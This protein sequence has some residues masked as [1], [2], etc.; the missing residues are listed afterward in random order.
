MATSPIPMASS[1]TLTSTPYGTLV[2]GNFTGIAGSPRSRLAMLD[3]AG[4]N[5]AFFAGPNLSSGDVNVSLLGRRHGS[6]RWP[7]SFNGRIQRLD[8]DGAL[9][10]PW[11]R[12]QSRRA[13]SMP[14]PKSPTP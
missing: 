6:G 5:T 1:I 7:E 4:R 10:S 13:I 3:A 8:G 2:G 9:L 11:S 14:W 12:F